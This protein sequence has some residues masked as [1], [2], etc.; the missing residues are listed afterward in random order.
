M[1]PGGVVK[2]VVDELYVGALIQASPEDVK[3]RSVGTVPRRPSGQTTR[4]RESWKPEPRPTGLWRQPEDV[5]GSG[6]A[7]GKTDLLSRAW[8]ID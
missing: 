8:Y 6:T 2:R 4:G 5:C 3:I 1:Q 7:Q